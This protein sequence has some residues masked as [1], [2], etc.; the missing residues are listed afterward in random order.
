MKLSTRARYALRMMVV[1][2]RRTNGEGNGNG[3]A[4]SLSQVSEETM[5]SRRYLEQL[6][7]GLKGSALI[8]GK[9]GRGGG[10]TLARSAEQITIREIIESAIG[11]INIV[12]CALQPE[13]CSMADVCEC[14]QLYRVINDRITSVMD[15]VVLSDIVDTSRLRDTVTALDAGLEASCRI[16]NND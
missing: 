14:R 11:P 8:R 3:R 4:V 13:I 5:I 16:K 10:Y 2:A 15:T 1:L 7:I 6:A 12:E 9:S